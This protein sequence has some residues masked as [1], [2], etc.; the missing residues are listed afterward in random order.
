MNKKVFLLNNWIVV[1]LCLL[2]LVTPIHSQMMMM[3]V[4]VL[5]AI[6][7]AQGVMYLL[8][9]AMK[10]YRFLFVILVVIII[11]SGTLVPVAQ[12]LVKGALLAVLAMEIFVHVGDG[13]LQYRQGKQTWMINMM[14]AILFVM[15]FLYAIFSWKS[16]FVLNILFFSIS[17]NSIFYL[18][19]YYVRGEFLGNFT[20][21]NM[22]AALYRDAFIPKG[23][24]SSFA[25]ANEEQLSQ[26]VKENQFGMDKEL[27]DHYVTVYL[28]TWQ[29][30]M[31]MMGHCDMSYKGKV[32]AFSNYDV[33]KM[34]FGGMM[35]VGTIAITSIKEYINFCTDVENKLVYGYTLRLNEK[36]VE[37]MDYLIEQLNENSHVWQPNDLSK[38]K[39]AELIMEKTDCV[40]R[41]VDRGSFRHYFVVGTNCV[42]LVDVMLN[43][44]GIKTKVSSGLL[45]PGQYFKMFD[46][47]SNERV[48]RKQVYWKEINHETVV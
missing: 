24:F 9:Y 32:Y 45:T 25:S 29:P 31:D 36:E 23:E 27:P 46:A 14:L 33:E 15:F 11:L 30:T 4:G 1:A 44:I 39:A 42:K 8:A 2:S 20:L 34:T 19:M 21:L 7:A 22:N 43:F 5:L 35:S 3:L 17:L 40:I 16:Q 6:K 48:V 38:N 18:V 41:E 37:Q 26:L 47:P 13:F 28:H 10:Q 12:F